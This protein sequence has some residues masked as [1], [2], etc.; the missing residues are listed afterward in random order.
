MYEEDLALN[1]FLWLICHKTQANQT[2]KC[3]HTH[4]YMYIIMIKTGKSTARRNLNCYIRSERF[5]KPT[6]L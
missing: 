2:F 1:N 3:T 4:T 5:E 6:E